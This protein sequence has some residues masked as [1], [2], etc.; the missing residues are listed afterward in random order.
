MQIQVADSTMLPDDQRDARV[1]NV[2]QYFVTNGLGSTLAPASPVVPQT[3]PP[4][5]AGL[6]ITIGV[7]CPHR[8]AG[9]G[10]GNGQ[11][12]PVCD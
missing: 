8:N 4:P 12:Q 11:S 3:Y 7:Q 10:Y 1:R 6:N 2:N 9:P 5:P